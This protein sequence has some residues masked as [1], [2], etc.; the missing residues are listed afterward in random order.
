MSGSWSGPPV[1]GEQ[2]V[3]VPR[4]G[5]SRLWYWVAGAAVLG[6]VACV[7]L[8]GLVWFASFSRQV[9]QFQRGPLPGQ[10]DLSF[11]SPGGYTV[12]FETDTCSG[13]TLAAIVAVRRRRARHRLPT[14]IPWA[15]TL[16]HEAVPAG[17]FPDPGRGHQ[18]RYWDGHTWTEHVADPPTPAA[19]PS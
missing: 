15:A 16:R 17:W 9:A 11:D 13:V 6:S 7:V 1:G 8:G 18:L 12:Y 4:I 3:G 14:P 10:T 5:P 2:A 19:Y